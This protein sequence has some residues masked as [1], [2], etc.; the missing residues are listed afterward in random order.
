MAGAA[1]K[2]RLTERQTAV[3]AA[4]ERIGRPIMRDL[5]AEFPHLAPSA[6][7]SV[8]TSLEKKDLV[9]HSGDWS[10]AYVDGVTWWSTAVEA[11]D[12]PDLDGLV[13]RLG[14][15]KLGLEL[16]VDPHERTVLIRLPLV[17]LES[18][19][20]GMPSGMIDRLRTCLEELDEAGAPARLTI[21]TALSMDPEPLLVLQLRPSEI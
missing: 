17:E 7:K 2:R 5:W 1:P 16:S 20:Q 9:A 19:L 14:E 11:G 12:D 18:Y 13:R 15:A 4:V 6:I 10:M 21:S 3:L 8:L